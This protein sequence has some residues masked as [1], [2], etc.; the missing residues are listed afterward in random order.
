M[1]ANLPLTTLQRVFLAD[2]KGVDKAVRQRM[3]WLAF[4]MRV[5]SAALMG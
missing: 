5:S 1:A 2:V 4:R 3:D